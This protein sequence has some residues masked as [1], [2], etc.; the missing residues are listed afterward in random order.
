MKLIARCPY[1]NSIFVC[2]NWFY[3]EGYGYGY[4]CWAC[5]NIDKIGHEVRNGIPY[6][7]LK[8]LFRIKCLL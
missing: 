5:G 3:S 8:F 1:C 6:F 2:W 7:V 4:E